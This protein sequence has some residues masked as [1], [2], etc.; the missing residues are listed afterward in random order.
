[1]LQST[2]S[3][4]STSS[5]STS[6]PSNRA[7][8]TAAAVTCP[9]RLR[10]SSSC[11]A[12]GINV[13]GSRRE[14]LEDVAVFRPAADRAGAI[15]NCH[16]RSCPCADFAFEQLAF[17]PGRPIIRH[18]PA[19]VDVFRTSTSSARGGQSIQRRRDRVL[20]DRCKEGSSSPPWRKAS[21]AS[22]KPERPRAFSSAT[23][24]K[25]GACGTSST[26]RLAI[27][28]AA[29]LGM[30]SPMP[31]TLRAPFDGRVRHRDGRKTMRRTGTVFPRKS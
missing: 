23:F 19:G 27:Q 25:V 28:P 18:A 9:S 2:S 4:S 14:Q 5:S 21:L 16:G 10:T 6:W 8:R 15:P 7:V 12:P 30:H 1:M 20:F 13:S 31:R 17:W 3:R 11:V 22:A 29:P 26:D 24:A